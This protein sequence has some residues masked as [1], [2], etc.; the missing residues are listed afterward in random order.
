[1]NAPVPGRL[2]GG[3]GLWHGS[4]LSD[5][6]AKCYKVPPMAFL[7]I[8][9]ERLPLAAAMLVALVAGLVYLQGAFNASD[10]KKG[11]ALALRHRPRAGG[12]SLFDALAA[13]HEGDPRCDGWI[14]SALFG[15]VRV[16]CSTP[17]RPDV[18]Y[19]FRVLLD[20][21]RPPRPESAAAESLLSG[22]AAAPERPADAGR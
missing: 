10:V 18:R 1:M 9:R 8:P 17:A 22:I 12:P 13:R 11:I 5:R 19:E 21:K 20:G 15:D 14:V 4:S 6:G 2:R 3:L 16:S 7:G